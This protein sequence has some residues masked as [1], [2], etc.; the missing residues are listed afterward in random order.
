MSQ[1][2]TS[3]VSYTCTYLPNKT[4]TYIYPQVWITE[5]SANLTLIDGLSTTSKANFLHT[6]KDMK[7]CEAPLSISNT[8]GF[9]L[10]LPCN[11]INLDGTVTNITSLVDAKRAA[12]PHNSCP[13]LSLKVWF[14]EEVVE[15]RV[16]QLKAQHDQASH[17]QT[18]PQNDQ[19][20]VESFEVEDQ[21]STLYNSFGYVQ[22]CHTYSTL[23][24]HLTYYL[25]LDT[26]FTKNLSLLN[27]SSQAPLVLDQGTLGTSKVAFTRE[28]RLASFA[29]L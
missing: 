18:S 15:A 14:K 10:I 3:K 13:Q 16:Y 12:S 22:L 2:K 28:V 11:L 5:L 27:P 4:S 26:S 17:F 21:A 1:S 29:F 8:S 6:L 7:L 23:F 19:T 9:P 25:E 20:E 24:H